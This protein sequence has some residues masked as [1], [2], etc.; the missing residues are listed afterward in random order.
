MIKTNH[1]LWRDAYSN[2]IDNIEKL[3]KNY[4][5]NF[6]PT[7]EYNNE[8]ENLQSKLEEHTKIHEIHGWENLSQ[9]NTIIS[10]SDSHTKTLNTNAN[11]IEQYVLA[12]ENES[13]IKPPQKKIKTPNFFSSQQIDEHISYEQFFSKMKKLNH[14]QRI[15]IDDIYIFKTNIHQNLFIFF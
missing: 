15:I 12:Y 11:E 1:N 5:Y 6:N 9:E 2:E 14:E 3:K 13:C 8:W 4:V 10:V 7:N